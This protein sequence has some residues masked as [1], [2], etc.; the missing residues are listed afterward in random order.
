MTLQETIQ[1]DFQKV[2]KS[3]LTSIVSHYKVLIGELQRQ[4]KKDLSDKE[5]ISII[6]KL[7]KYERENPNPDPI[8]L[9]TLEGYLPKQVEPEYIIKWIKENIDF[10]QYKNKIQAMKP[11]MQHFG[12]SVEGSVVRKILEDI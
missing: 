2:V 7:A 1:E 12:A 8:Y 6:K 3:K 10:D 11:I 9:A 4:P 5:V